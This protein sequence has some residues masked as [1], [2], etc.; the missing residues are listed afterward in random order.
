MG[1]T[2]CVFDPTGFFCPFVLKG[3]MLFQ[4]ATNLGLDWHDQLP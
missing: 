2:A 4:E 1:I 3:K